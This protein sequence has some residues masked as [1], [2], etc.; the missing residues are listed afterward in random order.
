MPARH[1]LDTNVFVYT[2]DRDSGEK[3]GRAQELVRE[4]IARRT[5]IISHQVIQEFLNLATRKFKTPLS[6]ADCRLYLDQ[7]LLPLWEVHP[8][9]ELY[10][11]AL[12]VQEDAGYSFYD[13]LMVS[14][15]IL[16][17]CR[18][19]YSEDLQDGKTIDGVSIRNP[20]K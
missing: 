4:A 14:A 2:F 10:R 1:F 18:V 11:K 7:V 19:L 12:L 17:G 5:G 15:A 16:A 6:P 3:R 9:R 8:T 20:F 13:S